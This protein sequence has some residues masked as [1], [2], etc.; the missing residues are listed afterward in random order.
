MKGVISF[1]YINE[2]IFFVFIFN[3]AYWYNNKEVGNTLYFENKQVIL[4]SYFE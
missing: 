1:N 3:L 4:F 2:K